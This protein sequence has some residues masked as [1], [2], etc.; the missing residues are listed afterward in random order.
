MRRASQG[1]H[2]ETMPTITTTDGTRIFYKDW[3]A[4]QPVMFSHGWPL[5]A[6]VWD[7]QAELVASSGYRAIA[8]DRRG[9]GRSD[10]HRDGYTMDRFADDLAE[11]IEQLNLTDI[12][13]VGH[14]MGGGEITRYLGRRGTS[15]VAKAVLLSAVP[16]LM[17]K[18]PD[19]PEGTSIEVFD[20]IREDLVADRAK[21][22][23]DLAAPFYGANR[24]GS[25]VSEGQLNS[26]WLWGMQAGLHAVLDC[27]KAFSETDF[28]ADLKRIDVPTLIVHG[29]DDQI[30]PIKASSL[31]TATLVKDA[32]L[33]VHKG[34][35]HGL[36]GAHERDFNDEL[37][38]F[39]KWQA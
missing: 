37:L 18:T 34:A 8:H 2:A 26:F 12:V 36:T 4:G 21:F 31:R 1:G 29:D 10:Q 6:D 14:S 35:P 19:N 24:D 11:L 7:R 17:L 27:V 13:L 30:V 25:T 38:T 20:A 33:K 15:R 32:T 39:L 9:F 28:T 23:R 22:Y 3:G 5:N 16:P